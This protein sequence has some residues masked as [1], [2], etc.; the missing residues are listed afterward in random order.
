M[1]E[2]SAE[3]SARLSASRR[4]VSASNTQR[5]LEHAS[6][7]YKRSHSSQ[8]TS[9]G[10][11]RS[12]AGARLNAE[13]MSHHQSPSSAESSAPQQVTVAFTR[14]ENGVFDARLASNA[15]RSAR[16]QRSQVRQR[17]LLAKQEFAEA[18]K[19]MTARQFFE[20]YNVELANGGY[21]VS[22]KV[23]SPVVTPAPVVSGGSVPSKE[24][25]QSEI[26]KTFASGPA[27]DVTSGD[28]GESGDLSV[29]IPEPSKSSFLDVSDE[30]LIPEVSKFYDAGVKDVRSVE[31]IAE[32]GVSKRSVDWAR[33]TIASSNFDLQKSLNR[34]TTTELFINS[35][36]ANP[37]AYR[38]N[39]IFSE[40]ESRIQ[41]F[42]DL[43]SVKT[44][45]ITGLS[46]G[47]VVVSGGVANAVLSVASPAGVGVLKAG[48]GVAQVAY[49]A[50]LAYRGS[51]IVKNYDRESPSA[52][53][54]DA[55]NLLAEAGGVVLGAGLVRSSVIDPDSYKLKYRDTIIEGDKSFVSERGVVS[56][57]GGRLLTVES[58]FNSEV[59]NTDFGSGVSGSYSLRVVRPSGKVGFS[60]AGVLSGSQWSYSVGK[61]F[62]Y[63]ND[64]L[65][66]SGR[67]GVR[68][69]FGEGFY[70]R[71][72]TGSGRGV[73]RDYSVVSSPGRSYNVFESNR[74]L[75][76]SEPSVLSSRTDGGVVSVKLRSRSLEAGSDTFVVSS[77]GRVS[78]VSR[79]AYMNVNR[80]LPFLS[81]DSGLSPSPSSFKPVVKEPVLS[82]DVVSDGLTVG[83]LP[84]DSAVLP[85]SVFGV[86]SSRVVESRNRLPVLDRSSVV[87]KPSLVVLNE[88]S[89]NSGVDTV[90]EGLVEPVVSVDSSVHSGSSHTSTP[91]VVTESVSDS[92]VDIMTETAVEPLKESFSFFSSFEP[93][94]V[95]PVPFIPGFSNRRKSRNGY[96]DV[97]VRRSGRFVKV[98][99]VGLSRGEAL[100]F[101]SLIAGETSVASFRVLRGSRAVY[102][103]EFAGFS[104]SSAKGSFSRRK[105]FFKK[106]NGVFIERRGARINTAGEL[107]EITYKG[108]SKIRGGGLFK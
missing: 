104:P 7:A 88:P 55:R 69:F 94:L 86:G 79:L 44:I 54:Y 29:F 61:R 16:L 48:A 64:L 34:D 71:F 8:Y 21:S 102:S 59:V 18:T 50:S 92:V 62:Y 9:G 32:V 68:R 66:T 49:G 15:E 13:R 4:A 99:T 39:K 82:T 45:A 91:D 84:V 33:S 60:D 42:E 83:L 78:P 106:K 23:L 90:S 36:D 52:S 17:N 76:D 70:Q 93:P 30:S 14:D 103:S 101:G 37:E 80:E 51:R 25:F 98:N 26:R 5:N 1:T 28:R 19:G 63:D 2:S 73:F 56:T 100:D 67:G 47:L 43:Q 35:P 46:A 65:L 24:A 107:G 27:L 20:S 22:P 41:D 40:A 97:E 105:R 72:D 11:A 53:Y 108:L 12:G 58:G 10:H 89:V 77:P 74:L 31:S 3:R 87:S 75:L 96:F 6:S 38:V 85:V 81:V 57:R 95:V